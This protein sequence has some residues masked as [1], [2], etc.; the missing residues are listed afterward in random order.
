M[1]EPLKNHFGPD[2]PV[3]LASMIKGVYSAFDS[4]GFVAHALEGYEEL[5][6]K[7]RGRKLAESL[8]AYLPESFPESADILVRS[9]GP[10]L[11]KTEGNGMAP[12]LYFP[13]V[14]YIEQHGLE[15]FDAAMQAQYELTQRFSAEF[16]IRPYIRRYTEEALTL[17]AEWTTDSSEHVRRLV[18]EGTRPRLPWASRIPEFQEDP[19]SVITLLERLKDDPSLYV[20]RSVANNLNDIGKDNPEILLDLAERWSVNADPNRKW[21]IKH[22]LR[23]LIKQGDVR[24]LAVLGIGGS[25]NL[26]IT[27]SQIRPDPAVVGDSIVISYTVQNLSDENVS[28]MA[29]FRVH[30]IKSNGKARPK[31]FKLKAFDLAG[32][33]SEVLRKKISVADMTTRK[34]YPGMHKVDALLNGTIAEIGQ[35]ELK[36]RIEIG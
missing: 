30:Y 3:R 25:E 11:L 27:A 6:L 4:D 8:S 1:G 33:E 18:S 28:V 13:H 23:S 24:A 14:C 9:A 16:S 20:R 10:K 29:D 17:L 19:S 15:H 7:D 2:I 26:Q 12:F 21:L 36:A 34:H 35:F 22:G 31:V 32:G 5:E